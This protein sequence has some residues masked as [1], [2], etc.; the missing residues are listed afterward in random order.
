MKKD[1]KDWATIH[2][3]LG[4][5]N[6]LRILQLLNQTKRLSVTDLAGELK[7][8]FKNTS[9]NLAILRHLGL[10]E[11]EG[12]ADR[13]YYSLSSKLDSEIHK[14]LSITIF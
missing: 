8:S 12:R 2:K 14:I 13:V 4:N 3:G 6:R 7:I 5:Q 11:F 9:R 1:I 10:V